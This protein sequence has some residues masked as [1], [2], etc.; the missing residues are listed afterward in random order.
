MKYIKLREDKNMQFIK[1]CMLGLVFVISAIIGKSLSKK[2]SYRLEELEEIKNSL[3]ILKT[4]IKFTYEPLPEIFEEI[5]NNTNYNIS[6]IFKIAKNKMKNN[7]ANIAWE[8]S[9]NES[10][11][12]L[13]QEDKKALLT[14]S[15]LLGQTDIKGQ[16]SQIELTQT[17]LNKQISQ[18][19][20]EKKKNEKLYSKLGTTVGLMIVIIL[21]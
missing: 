13:N 20:E 19:I 9:V 7:S 18:A 8:Q 3:N 5:S 10:V 12:N 15:K 4:K 1:I 21:I 16:I 11:N 17:F 2:Y 14:L 6:Q